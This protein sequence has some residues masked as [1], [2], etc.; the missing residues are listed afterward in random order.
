[1]LVYGKSE[2]HFVD[3]WTLLLYIKYNDT[4]KFE[5]GILIHFVNV[6]VKAKYI[7]YLEHSFYPFKTNHEL[8]H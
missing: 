3:R 6:Y 7:S 5:F 1:M 8:I 4:L 2:H